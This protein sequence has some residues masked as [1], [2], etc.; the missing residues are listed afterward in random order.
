[1]LVMA[2]FATSIVSGSL[3]LGCDPIDPSYD[4]AL[5]EKALE[6]APVEGVPAESGDDGFTITSQQAFSLVVRNFAE[7]EPRVELQGNRPAINTRINDIQKPMLVIETRDAS[8]I[9]LLQVNGKTI[10]PQSFQAGA[11]AL[12]EEL[13]LVSQDWLPGEFAM[14]ELAALPAGGSV[15]ADINVIAAPGAA[16]HFDAFGM[17][18]GGRALV[19]RKGTAALYPVQYHAVNVS[20]SGTGVGKVISEPAGIDCGEACSSLFEEGSTVKLRSLP[21]TSDPHNVFTGWGGACAEAGSRMSCDVPVTQEQDVSAQYEIISVI[22]LRAKKTYCG[23]PKWEN[24]SYALPQRVVTVIPE[25]IPVDAGNAGN[26]WLSIEFGDQ[27]CCYKGG[28]DQAHPLGDHQIG[29]GKR[30]YFQR[31]ISEASISGP[32]H[33]AC[34]SGSIPSLSYRAGDQIEAA[35]S[36]SLRIDNGDSYQPSTEVSHDFPV[37]RW[38][39]EN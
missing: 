16:L 11:P 12:V 34:M 25:R 29:K 8:K 6:V 4:D 38:I 21:D 30:Y 5:I 10:D 15:R 26:H 3:M 19:S 28:S 37:I 23:V 14:V 13:K 31:C 1:M 20:V 7:S 33:A 35:G 27:V 17:V 22:P 18:W 2:S 32:T 36:I 9:W 24:G 39:H